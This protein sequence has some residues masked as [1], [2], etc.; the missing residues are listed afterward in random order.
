M[1]TP[2]EPQPK[3]PGPSPAP[4]K[5]PGPSAAPAKNKRWP[6]KNAVQRTR[7][8]TGLLVVVAGDVAIAVAAIWGIIKTGQAG[9][10]SA[11]E[12]AI[13]TS[14]FTAIGTM[15]TAYFG[16]KSMSN[17]AQSL[18]GGS[19]NNSGAGNATNTGRTPK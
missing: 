7:A 6:S 18:G 4:A 13:L 2:E 16:I 3:E 15:T 5:E 11:S 19:G 10:A 17:T 12:V 8:W 1:T 9:T 14:A